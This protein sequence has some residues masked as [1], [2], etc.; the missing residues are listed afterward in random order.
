MSGLKPVPNA[1][2]LQ[3][4]H[5]CGGC[6]YELRGL[7]LHGDCPECGTPIEASLPSLAPANAAAHDI[8]S[9]LKFI[10]AGWL[11]NAILILG[12]VSLQPILVV[13]LVGAAF[14]CTG[15]LRIHRALGGSIWNERKWP[16]WHASLSALVTS[17]LVA[18]LVLAII[19]V[20]DP[21]RGIQLA[22]LLT[23]MGS[24]L[25]I[26]VEAMG[27]LIGVRSWARLAEYP[28]LGPASTALLAVWTVPCILILV[29]MIVHGE[30]VSGARWASVFSTAMLG[31]VCLGS[32]ANA[33]LG[34]LFSDLIHQRELVPDEIEED[35]LMV[36]L[37]NARGLA[38]PTDRHPLE[39]AEEGRSPIIHQRRGIRTRK[40]P[41]KS[42]R[43]PPGNP[44]G[45]Y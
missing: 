19:S 8:R 33:L 7:H 35:D 10:N 37:R 42:P 22:F 23:M 6:G 32:I 25:L 30:L 17:G 39:T 26:G 9:G 14:R 28:V 12:C 13:A 21:G 24:L 43:K 27:W 38:E 16:Q 29:L 4:S 3:V 5:A 45:I 15:Y 11:A 1:L 31:L 36:R 20:I 2:F 40:P 41:T 34:T 44:G 18:G